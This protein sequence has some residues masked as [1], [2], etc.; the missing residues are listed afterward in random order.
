MRSADN[1]KHDNLSETQNAFKSIRNHIKTIALFSLAF[2]LVFTSNAVEF[3]QTS[4]H[5]TVIGKVFN[6]A[7]IN[8]IQD[9]NEYGIPGV[10]LAT[11]TGLII[12]TDGYG[13]YHIPDSYLN[14]YISNSHARNFVLKIDSASLPICSTIQSENPSVIRLSKGSIN[15]LN[16]AITY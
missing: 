16:F 14:S 10:R 7:N 12:E 1:T 11:V 3:N 2:P 15:K 4:D 8:G 13:R 6:D 5:G 9:T